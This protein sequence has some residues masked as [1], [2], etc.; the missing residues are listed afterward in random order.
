MKPLIKLFSQAIICLDVFCAMARAKVN[1]IREGRVAVLTLIG[2]KTYM[3]G[4][5]EFTYS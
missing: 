4:P 2:E 5:C 3:N 1:E